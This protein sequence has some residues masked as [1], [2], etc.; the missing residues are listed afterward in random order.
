MTLEQLFLALLAVSS[1]GLG[2]FARELYS[3]VNR[4]STR[5]VGSLPIYAPL[6][7]DTEAY[8]VEIFASSAHATAGT[9]VVRTITA[10]SQTCTYTSAQRTADGTGSAVVYMR[11]YQL[12]AAVGRGY[13][14]I[15][16][17]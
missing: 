5:L 8:E 15:T 9:P 17:N 16:S 4:L 11:V 10:T 3:A 12:S 6:G 7:E 1:A 13:P 2:W 14:L